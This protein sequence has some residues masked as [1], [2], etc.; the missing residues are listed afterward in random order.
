MTLADIFGRRWFFII[1]S[2]IALLG[3]IVG[4]VAP[5]IPTLI[6]AETLIG[7][8]S[9]AQ[10]C[11]NYAIVELVP[12]KHRFLANGFAFLWLILANGFGSVIAYG[13]IYKTP[14]G[15]RGVFYL[16]IALNTLCTSC[17][18][19]FYRP[20]T[21]DMKHGKGRKM[22]FVKNFDYV[23]TFLSLLGQLLFLMGLSWVR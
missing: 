2:A 22:E 17:W 11:F 20:P 16:L 15:W 4:A 7:F 19:L 3:S 21:F 1:G 18:Y 10:I 8:G 14:V 9:S 6:A 13:F 23:G 5:N 12:L